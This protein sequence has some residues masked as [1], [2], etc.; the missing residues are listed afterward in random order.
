MTRK[1]L[2]KELADVFDQVTN[3]DCDARGMHPPAPVLSMLTTPAT[4]RARAAIRLEIAR[5]DEAVGD[6]LASWRNRN[7]AADMLR[8]A[9]EPAA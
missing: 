1:P 7:V 9:E 5:Q 2:P 4:L 3:Y 8:R 6:T